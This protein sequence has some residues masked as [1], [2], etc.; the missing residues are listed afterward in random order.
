[1]CGSG[2]F[3]A[4]F[5][6]GRADRSHLVASDRE[7]PGDFTDLGKCCVSGLLLCECDPDF[8]EIARDTVYRLHQIAELL[9]DLL[10]VGI[11]G[12]RL[13]EEFL[14]LI[15][16]RLEFLDGGLG[17][18]GRRLRGVIEE[19]ADLL[20]SRGFPDPE[21]AGRARFGEFRLANLLPGF[22]LEMVF[23]CCPPSE[24][25]GHGCS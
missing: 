15:G 13:D 10:V 16:L 18:L 2:G 20:H 17:L 14:I 23:R 5:L 21:D 22:S 11:V 12:R 7:F 3:G 8:S 1:M 19:F 6:K 24:V 9:F 25:T 4:K